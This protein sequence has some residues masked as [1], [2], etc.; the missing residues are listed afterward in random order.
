MRIETVRL[1]VFTLDGVSVHDIS[2]DLRVFVAGT[3]IR[4]GLCLLAL[5]DPACALTI[6]DDL[7]D[8][9]DDL[10][11]MGRNRLGEAA[12]EPSQEG[13]DRLDEIPDPT[14]LTAIVCEALTLPVRDGQ[15]AS[16]AWESIVMIDPGG[17]AERHIDVTV[18]G[19]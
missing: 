12:R 19:E 9:Y 14:F 16:G 8:T 11:R 3:G 18:V 4:L 6:T 17:P 2:E 10:I 5:S 7:E 13:D 15:L 1:D